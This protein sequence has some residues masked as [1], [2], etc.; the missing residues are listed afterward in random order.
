MFHNA[1]LRWDEGIP[2]VGVT[3]RNLAVSS[4]T[5][6]PNPRKS[7][8][9]RWSM[10]IG[11]VEMDSPYQ[12]CDFNVDPDGNWTDKSQI[13]IRALSVI[14]KNLVPDRFVLPMTQMLIM[15]LCSYAWSL[16]VILVQFDTTTPLE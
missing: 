15:S 4:T 11:I 9:A 16:L 8:A 14:S 13:S 6:G 3:R 5:M 7:I 12:S 2:F 1:I 10:A